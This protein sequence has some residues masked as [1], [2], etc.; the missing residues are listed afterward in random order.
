MALML[1]DHQRLP[2]QD[3]L[4]HAGLAASLLRVVLLQSQAHLVEQQQPCLVEQQQQ[5]GHAVQHHHVV[6]P[7]L[8]VG[9]L[10]RR[11]AAHR[12][13]AEVPLQHEVARAV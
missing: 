10:P 1:L 6:P 5:S 4:R 9:H 3:S 2:L 12:Q 8:R 7:L 11:V 13:L